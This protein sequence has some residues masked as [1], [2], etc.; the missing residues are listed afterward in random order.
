MQPGSLLECRN[1]EGW[2]CDI[3]KKEV[4]GPAF[5]EIVTF[6]SP[7][8]DPKYKDN[9]FLV[10]YGYKCTCGCGSSSSMPASLFRELQPPL[11]IDI[12]SIISQPA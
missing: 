4:Q 11:N 1:K 8:H 10:E 3:S 9:I 5:E 12:E 2:T 6:E 7:D